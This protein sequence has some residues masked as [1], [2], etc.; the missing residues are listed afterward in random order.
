MKKTIAFLSLLVF[1]ASLVVAVE[2][3]TTYNPFTGRQD[4]ITGSNFSGDNITVDYLNV[5][6]NLLVGGN[7]SGNI[8]G[9]NLSGKTQYICGNV[10]D[11]KDAFEGEFVV[12]I[13][14]LNNVTFLNYTNY[15]GQTNCTISNT[16]CNGTDVNLDGNVTFN[17]II[18]LRYDFT[19]VYGSYNKVQA[20]STQVY[21]K[22]N[23]ISI[24]AFD[25]VVFGAGMNISPSTYYRNSRDSV[26]VGKNASYIVFNESGATFSEKQVSFPHTV[27]A[28]NFSGGLV[29]AFPGEWV[30]VRRANVTEQG[31]SVGTQS[32]VN[33][34]YQ[35]VADYVGNFSFAVNNC[36]L[37]NNRCN[38]VD[39]SLDGKNNGVDIVLSQIYGGYVIG[40][41]SRNSAFHSITVGQSNVNTRESIYS[42]L[43]GVYLT[44]LNR[45]DVVIVG[46]NKSLIT[47]N[48]T[49]AY[50]QGNLTF[51]GTICDSNGCIGSGGGSNAS[52]NFTNVA[53]INESQ[54][55]TGTPSYQGGASY[56]SGTV[57]YGSASTPTFE[58]GTNLLFQNDHTLTSDSGTVSFSGAGNWIF[59]ERLFMDAST[60]VYDLNSDEERRNFTVNAF[61]T[62]QQCY[63]LTGTEEQTVN[64][65][66]MGSSGELIF[67]NGALQSDEFIFNG[68]VQAL[69]W[70][71]VTI[72]ASQVSGISAGAYNE[73]YNNIL[74]QQCPSGQVVN[75]TLANGTFTCVTDQTG[76]GG[77]ASVSGGFTGAVNNSHNYTFWNG[78][79]L[80]TVPAMSFTSGQSAVGTDALVLDYP[81]NGTDGPDE[82]PFGF[83]TQVTE[84]DPGIQ[85]GDWIID[86]SIVW[87]IN[88]VDSNYRHIQMTGETFGR[89]MYFRVKN[90][91]TN[92]WLEWRLI[93][94][95]NM[96]A[97]F[98]LAGTYNRF[99]GGVTLGDPD[100]FSTTHEVTVY[101]DASS[102][103]SSYRD[104]IRAYSNVAG[105]S[106]AGVSAWA[107][108]TASGGIL[109]VWQIV[110]EH[111]GAGLATT[112]A[113]MRLG[114]DGLNYK[115]LQTW[116]QTGI[117]VNGSIATAG[118]GLGGL[119]PGDIN[120]STVYYD[121]LTA[122]SPI[123]QCSQGTNWCQVTVP[124]YQE[125]LFIHFDDS[126]NPQEV[127][128]RGNTYTP[129]Q[130]IQNICPT[131]SN[132]EEICTQ[133]IQK[134]QK[135]KFKKQCDNASGRVSGD[136]C[137][138]TIIQNVSREEAIESY[139]IN[140]SQTIE[141]TCLE[142]DVNLTVQ[143]VTCSQEVDTD[144][145]ITKYRFINGCSWNEQNG[146]YCNAD[147]EIIF[148]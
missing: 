89:Y 82:Y 91:T 83:Y 55:Y 93:P 64:M 35:H 98:Q 37:G 27:F 48:Q 106:W 22:E 103:S 1:L 137:F 44:N 68:E 112:M 9:L 66:C 71:N 147:R 97:N 95:N 21:G 80:L 134:Y 16:W 24:G 46:Y 2:L 15:L 53:Y 141:T 60:G 20:F 116:T 59:G 5:N 34:T 51:N 121:T 19:Q 136:S 78:T 74:N 129:Q 105:G 145:L 117:T 109:P 135:L 62:G 52:A 133:I 73:T 108:T 67:T 114:I 39:V 110:G 81:R 107:R 77:G 118:N 70:S 61:G 41:N 144:Q 102:V 17:D 40:S 32:M 124:E 10:Y 29:F 28:R 4:F 99:N 18:K 115:T 45:S 132:T 94:A 47:W 90:S 43:F 125:S 25:S 84:S 104:Q 76:G 3:R 72:S 140:A 79:D 6:Q 131:N 86:G 12:L 123:F 14:C 122:K 58:D 11:D 26:Y 96:T 8:D 143:E 87:G 142:L 33:T 30:G 120:V 113:E 57:L 119:T 13:G 130:F 100:F 148:K 69:D 75:G 31:F 7:F 92:T 126:Y 65:I 88:P 85:G 101:E 50:G 63:L 23:S 38:G 139:Q 128:F 54:S 138:E 49:G 146:Y 111:T 56:D 36:T 127:I 42:A